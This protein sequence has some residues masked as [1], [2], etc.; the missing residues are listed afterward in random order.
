MSKTTKEIRSNEEQ[1]NSVITPNKRYY[2]PLLD[3]TV[4]AESLEEAKKLAIQQK[5]T[6]VG[7]DV[8]Q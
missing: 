6:K 3:R 1:G 4:E 7:D 2:F 5:D 8:I